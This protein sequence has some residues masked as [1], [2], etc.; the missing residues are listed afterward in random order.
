MKQVSIHHPELGLVGQCL[1]E[2]VP[3]WERKGWVVG[4]PPQPAP[5]GD[6]TPVATSKKNATEDQEA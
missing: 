5:V 2:S 1:P 3:A 4:T 6:D